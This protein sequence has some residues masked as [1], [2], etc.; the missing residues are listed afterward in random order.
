MSYLCISLLHIFV[1]FML[2]AFSGFFFV[3]FFLQYCD[4]VGG[5]FDL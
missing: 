2:F 5:S 4:T 3:A 1:Y